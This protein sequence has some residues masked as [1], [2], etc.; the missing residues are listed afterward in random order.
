MQLLAQYSTTSDNTSIVVPLSQGSTPGLSVVAIV[1][2]FAVANIAGW[3]KTQLAIG[4]TEQSLYILP[5]ASHTVS[6]NNV[7]VNLN[8]AAGASVLI[9]E[10]DIYNSTLSYVG[11][12]TGDTANPAWGTAAHPSNKSQVTMGFLFGA[13]TT[14]AN[15]DITISSWNYGATFGD[16][17]S[18]SGSSIGNTRLYGVYEERSRT[19]FVAQ[20]SGTWASADIKLGGLIGY[21][22]ITSA[23]ST[24]SILDSSNM[25]GTHSEHTDGTPSVEVGN[26][27]YRYGSAP[28]WYDNSQVVGARIYLDAGLT[29]P[30]GN[31]TVNAYSNAAGIAN[32]GSSLTSFG[33]LSATYTANVSTLSTG[34]NEIYFPTP[35][36][37]PANNG[38]VPITIQFVGNPA[39]YLVISGFPNKGTSIGAY[40]GTK[41]V[42]SEDGTIGYSQSVYR[43]G[44]TYAQSVLTYPVDILMSG[45]YNNILTKSKG[46]ISLN[47]DLGDT[48]PV[49]DTVTIS[50]SDASGVTITHSYNA[51]WLNVTPSSGTEPIDFTVSVDPTGLD[52][53]VYN[54]T[55]T[56]SGSGYD[57]ITLN[58][59]FTIVATYVGRIAI[60]NAHMGNSDH[61]QY[62]V[63]NG[64]VG[65]LGFAKQFSVN[66]GNTIDFAVDGVNAATIDIYRVG[67]YNNAHFRKLATL[68][69]TPT[70]QSGGV[71]IA[72]SNGATSMAAWSTTASWS[73][74]SNTVSGLFIGTVKDSIGDPKSWIPFV[75]RNDSVD[76]DIVIKLSDSTWAAAYNYFGD[77]GTEKTGKSV[78]GSGGPLGTI[79]TRSYAVSYDR[80]IVSRGPTASDPVIN[81]WDNHE[82]SLIDWIEKNGYN[83]KY[84]SSYDLD[85]QH[86][87]DVLGNAK[88]LLCAGH[89]EYWSQ[90]MWDNAAAFR[91]TGKHLIFMSGNEVF[92]RIRYTDAGRVVWCYKDTA[93]GG[94]AIDPVSW[95]GTWSDI[96][97]PDDY[98]PQHYM[99]GTF[100][101]MNNSPAKNVTIVGADYSTSPFWRDTPVELGSDITLN[102]LIGFEADD[103]A[104][105]NAGGVL[106][107]E[108]TVN[109]DGS[110]A[111][112]DGEDYGG[113]GDLH[114][115]IACFYATPTSGMTVGFGTC[116][117]MW[118][119]SNWHRR[120]SG[121]LVANVNARQAMHN[122]LYDMTCSAETIDSDVTEPTPVALSTYGAAYAGVSIT[123]SSVVYPDNLT[124]SSVV[125]PQNYA[126][127]LKFKAMANASVSR[128]YMWKESAQDMAPT[129]AYLLN[130]ST[131]TI[132]DT[133]NVDWGVETGWV[134]AEFL[135]PVNILKG[136]IY[137]ACILIPSAFDYTFSQAWFKVPLNEGPIMAFGSVYKI[138]ATAT[139]TGLLSIDNSYGIDVLTSSPITS[140]LVLGG[141]NETFIKAYL[142]SN[143]V[144]SIYLGSNLLFGSGSPP[145]S[146]YQTHSIFDTWPLTQTRHTDGGTSS[147][148]MAQGFYLGAVSATKGWGVSGGRIHIPTGESAN[149]P[150][151][152][153]LSLFTASLGSLPNLQSVPL[154]TA[155]ANVVDGWVEATWEPYEVLDGTVEYAWISAD[156]GDTAYIYST[157]TLPAGDV[158]AS[159]GSFAYFV[160]TDGGAFSS[161]GGATVLSSGFYGIDIIFVEGATKYNSIFNAWP[162]VGGTTDSPLSTGVEFTLSQQATLESVRFFSTSSTAQRDCGIWDVTGNSW[163]VTGSVTPDGTNNKWVD[164]PMTATLEAGKRYK[165]IVFHSDGSYK[166]NGNY[167]GSNDITSGIITVLG[168]T[169]ATNGNGTYSYGASLSNTTSTFGGANYWIDVVVSYNNT[170]V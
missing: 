147:I 28:G 47:A 75:V 94:V 111:D 4:A 55:I 88:I 103:H 59:Q 136:D 159:D 97:R 152:V 95:T 66:A 140:S 36:D 116:Q 110:Y 76:A 16:T 126:L 149:L 21:Y 23:T 157:N 9:F 52:E 106:L 79:G 63:G 87:T 142:G 141:T 62:V 118:G 51:A 67:H 164:A 163:V 31:F 69:N 133:V 10:D 130:M 154:R 99:T 83:V 105:P 160:R 80:P 71:T 32:N 112:I 20:T 156:F 60:E 92:W 41:L 39:Y 3:T 56:F 158:Q 37:M 42:L 45:T 24:H 8:V 14:N 15:I 89:D 2:S 53:G 48:T 166:A 104:L 54:D 65:Y 85:Q 19:G 70:A 132:L 84:I 26:V 7:T 78:Y 11:N 100:F 114:W 143:I 169:N 40:D 61:G 145:T 123:P 138:S 22:K 155:T 167:F 30:A 35:F 121:T 1:N 148:I 122:L 96:R 43:L 129:T 117:W 29:L 33:T 91:N 12:A 34:W 27:F 131:Q 73:V 13:S 162:V 44:S 49:N 102:S 107:G 93:N 168:N 124:A 46:S 72:N 57:D 50:T 101:R 90:E 77:Q 58:V 161:D 64:V 86:V 144:D 17:G 151:T 135:N 165:A 18:S 139:T 170:P 98:T 108:T 74:P 25:S 127:G 82:S 150:S 134:Y 113:N 68:T 38:C 120:E 115:G 6:L 125:D 81:H 137:A 109:I 146:S 5:A 119:L 128:I 153:T